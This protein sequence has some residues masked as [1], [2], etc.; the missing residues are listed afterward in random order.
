MSQEFEGRVAL[1]T[2]AGAGIG[3]AVARAF[4][5]AGARVGVLDRDPAAAAATVTA[6]ASTGGAALALPADVRVESEVAAAVTALADAYGGIDVLA[7]VAGVV[8]YG[9]APDFTEDDWDFVI[10]V[11]LKG[12]FLTA[13]HVIP[14]LR[15]RGGGAIV[16]TASVQAFASQRTVAA[17]S[18]SKGGVVSMTRTLALDHAHEGIRVNAIAPGSVRTPM[19]QDAAELF[20]P[21]DPAA[22]LE[23]WGRLHPIGRVIEPAEVAE[24]VLFLAG[25]RSAAITGTTLL[26]DGGL[27]AGLPL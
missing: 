11:N 7:N 23:G 1:V 27:S 17:Y 25:P 26:I 12:P 8:R 2:G 22:T 9:E 19:L 16:N 20:G 10:D 3:A 18:A 15:A 5:D 21:D 24:A 4:A 13:R 14:H 6:I